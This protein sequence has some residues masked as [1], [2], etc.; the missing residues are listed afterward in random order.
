[1]SGIRNVCA[2]LL[3]TTALVSANGAY[4]Q[5][6]EETADNENIIVVT[7]SQIQG[8]KI[9]DILPVTVLDEGL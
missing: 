8:A 2:L 7:G 1:M 4:A 5:S 9:N 3:G 6:A